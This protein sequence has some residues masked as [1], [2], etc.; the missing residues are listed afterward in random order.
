MQNMKLK[1]LAVSATAFAAMTGNALAVGQDYT[2]LTAG[3]TENI[4]TAL[5]AGLPIAGL[6]LG[7]TV[8]LRFLRKI[9]K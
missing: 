5:T 9:V 4:G 2:S 8:G 7:A 6:I 3:V 1:G